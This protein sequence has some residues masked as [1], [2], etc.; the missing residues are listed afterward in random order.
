MPHPRLPVSDKNCM[1]CGKPM[2]RKTYPSGRLEDRTVFEK[3][4][5][6]NQTCMASHM[7]GVIKN[8]N[9][10][11]SRRQATKTRKEACEVCARSDTRLHVHH[12][13]G[14]PQNNSPENLTT[15]CGSCHRKCHSPHFT[16]FPPQRKPCEYC[17]KDAM[18]KGLCYTHLTRLRKH[19]DPTLVRRG[20]K[21]GTWL[22][23]A[24]LPLV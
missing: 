21:C 22:E 10:T 23:K 5:F 11:N 6:C 12:K 19:G 9:E 24:D 14:N 3:R 18:R 20:N 15:L 2:I 8:P 16:G 13:D 4:R 1:D 7:E 17:L